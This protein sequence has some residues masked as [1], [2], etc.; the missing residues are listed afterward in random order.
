MVNINPDSIRKRPI[1][2]RSLEDLSKTNILWNMDK[3]ADFEDLLKRELRE[4]EMRGPVDLPNPPFENLRAIF[5][6]CNGLI[7]C[8]DLK[9]NEDPI[10]VI[11][12]AKK[13]FEENKKE[14]PDKK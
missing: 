10:P 9:S 4:G 1:N 3:L 12:K 5:I 14:T 2:T 6:K 13:Y 8:F 11:E 7:H